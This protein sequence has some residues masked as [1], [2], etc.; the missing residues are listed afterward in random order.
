VIGEGG[1]IDG[2][3]SLNSTADWQNG[4]EEIRQYIITRRIEAANS[5]KY[6]ISG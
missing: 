2:Y 3:T 1:E 5:W 6:S 4:V